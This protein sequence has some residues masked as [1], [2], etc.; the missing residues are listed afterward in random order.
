MHCGSSSPWPWRTTTAQAAKSSWREIP[1]GARRD[2]TAELLFVVEVPCRGQPLPL[3][4]AQRLRRRA[5]LG[6]TLVEV[7]GELSSEQVLDRP[8]RRDDAARAGAQE[9]ALQAGHARRE[10]RRTDRAFAGAQEHEVRVAAPALNLPRGEVRGR[11]G[12]CRRQYEQRSERLAEIRER[13]RGE[14]RSEE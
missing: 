8:Q 1:M 11:A 7:F 10:S 3:S 14:M 12:V 6:V 5:R 13:M 2:A 9:R 4:F